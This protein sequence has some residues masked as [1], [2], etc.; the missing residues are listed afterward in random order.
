MNTYI[1]QVGKVEIIR[2]PG[3]SFDEVKE[4]LRKAI[5]Q[6]SGLKN[7]VNVEIL[8]KRGANCKPIRH[9]YKESVSEVFFQE[10]F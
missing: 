1:A 7:F 9:A 6:H 5:R 2:I 4:E 10:H 8:E 3:K